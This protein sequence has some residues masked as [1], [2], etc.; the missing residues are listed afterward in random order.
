M[1]LYD[2]ITI[3]VR[4]KDEYN[5]G[6]IPNAINVP[7]EKLIIEPEKYIVKGETYYIYCKKG[8]ATEVVCEI[9]S[10]EG[11]TVIEL[12][13]GYESWLIYNKES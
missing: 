2:P 11:Y 8:K 12:E 1:K 4:E 6:H 10:K 13:K 3:D 5:L 9:L 7:M